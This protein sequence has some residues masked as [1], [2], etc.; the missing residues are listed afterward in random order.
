MSTQN[1]S[2]QYLYLGPIALL[3]L[4]NI[5]LFIKNQSLKKEHKDTVQVLE[6]EKSDLQSEY[7]KTLAELDQYKI[8]VQQKDSTL[9]GLES[10]IEQ[11]KKEIERILS[12]SNASKRELEQ[13]RT[14]IASLQTSTDDYKRQ[15]DALTYQNQQLTQENTGLKTDVAQKE[16][17]IQEKAANISQLEAEK[18]ELSAVKQTLSEQK[19]QLSATVQRGSVMQ[20]ANITGS[21]VN[22]KKGGKEVATSRAKRT[23]QLKVCF[24]I[25]RNPIA[26]AGKKEIMLRI[27]SPKGDALSVE[28]M[29]S[30]V[31]THGDTGEQ[32]KYTTKATIDYQNQSENYCMYWEQNSPFEK[33]NY[34]AEIYNEGYLIGSGAFSI[35]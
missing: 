30:G 4:L 26:K 21:A 13:A 33:G 18:S 24:D 7:Q 23:D 14:L 27:M 19:D 34:T 9:T 11:Q 28:S 1:N 15:I 29:G 6:T 31:F 12:K 32:M 35:K 2:R 3:F 22:L 5:F 25:M 17:T 20:A 16:Q 8:D 10:Q